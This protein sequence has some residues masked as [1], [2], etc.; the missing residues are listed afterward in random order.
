[1]NWTFTPMRKLLSLATYAFVTGTMMFSLAACADEPEVEDDFDADTTLIETP[2]YDT[3]M[4]DTTMMDTTM[5][6][7]TDMGM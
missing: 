5:A 2:L 7:T 1:M 3:T 6:D 4:Y